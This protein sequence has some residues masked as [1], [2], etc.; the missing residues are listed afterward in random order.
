MSI[1][2]AYCKKH[3]EIEPEDNTEMWVC[4]QCSK[5]NMKKLS[6]RLPC[7]RLPLDKALAD[8]ELKMRKK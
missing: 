2:N 7:G 3:D 5:E 8:I 1:P 6:K 4:P